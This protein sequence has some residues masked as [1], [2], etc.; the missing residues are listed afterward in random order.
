MVM[1]LSN[2]GK[3][4]SIL[5]QNLTR[6]GNAHDLFDLASIEQKRNLRSAAVDRFEG[7]GGSRS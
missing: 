6:G 5:R 1:P 2:L 7:R 4:P 3:S